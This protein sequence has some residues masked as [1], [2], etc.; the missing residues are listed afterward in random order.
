MCKFSIFL[1]NNENYLIIAFDVGGTKNKVGIK[2]INV[3][4]VLVFI[5]RNR[6]ILE[7]HILLQIYLET[8]FFFV[9]II[10]SRIIVEREIH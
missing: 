8:L 6:K 10:T 9:Q 4:C 5:K 3:E 7:K 1:H 2:C